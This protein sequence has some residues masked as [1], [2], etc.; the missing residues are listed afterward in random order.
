MQVLYNEAVPDT[1]AVSPEKQAV[2]SVK[3][4]AKM[5]AKM[6]D[7][8]WRAWLDLTFE[9]G[10]EKT[11]LRRRHFGP[12]VIQRPFY[13]EGRTC[14]AYLLH[15]PGGVVGGDRLSVK[16]DCSNNASGLITTPGANRFYGSDGRRAQQIQ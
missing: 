2:H 13:P 11:V 14:H 6:D 16:V 1:V 4:A 9:Q 5:A 3:M 8:S 7:G 12:L 15:P 10:Q